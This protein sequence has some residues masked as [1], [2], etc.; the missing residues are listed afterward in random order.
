L[1]NYLKNILK[2]GKTNLSTRE[3]WLKKTLK[4]LPY[5]LKILDAG[6]GES[7]YK[8]FCSH[9]IYLSQDFAQYDG[10]GDGHALQTKKWDNS[11]LDYVSDI[12]SIP[13]ENETFDA[14]MCVEVFEHIP[15][16]I[17]AL[18]EFRRILKKDGILILTAPVCSLTHFAPYYFYN[19]FSKY[20]YEKFLD[21]N[22]FEI[23]EMNSNGSWYEY[24]AQELHRL[25]YI[26]EKYSGYKTG[27]VK[28]ALIEILLMPLLLFFSIASNKDNNS[29]EL[30][31]FGL[32]IK[33]FKV[34]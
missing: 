15:E 25:P 2:I 19:G 23:I 22:G 8:K 11:K 20:F 18:K 21:Q 34:R 31:S 6:A 28:K 16:P 29:Q 33:A 1:E 10:A 9:L 12:T 13:V 17:E 5:G 14:V 27:R 7:Q 3:S 26:L 30:L 24:V 32:H 4:G